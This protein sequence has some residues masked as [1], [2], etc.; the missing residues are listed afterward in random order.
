VACLRRMCWPRCGRSR[1]SWTPRRCS[2]VAGRRRRRA[3]ASAR[4]RALWSP[5]RCVTGVLRMRLTTQADFR[6]R[7]LQACR[8]PKAQLSTRC[9]HAMLRRGRGS[10]QDRRE[11]FCVRFADDPDATCGCCAGGCRA[12]QL[13]LCCGCTGLKTGDTHRPAIQW[14]TTA[15]AY[16]GAMKMHDEGQAGDSRSSSSCASRSRGP[17]SPPCARGV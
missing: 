6:H 11:S 4:G 1:C 16:T 5:S 2:C 7:R 14:A 12:P 17:P 10:L 3:G 8:P 15:I 9:P 13:A